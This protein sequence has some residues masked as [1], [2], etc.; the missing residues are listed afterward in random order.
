MHTSAATTCYATLF[1]VQDELHSALPVTSVILMLAEFVYTIVQQCHA[2]LQPTVHTMS[3]IVHCKLARVAT[4]LL[5][6]IKLHCS[7]VAMSCC[8]ALHS[9]LDDLHTVTSCT[10]HQLTVCLY[11]LCTMFNATTTGRRQADES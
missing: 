5:A 7:N 11:V 9:V 8:T 2:L 4:D 1:C 3:C 10:A 6:C